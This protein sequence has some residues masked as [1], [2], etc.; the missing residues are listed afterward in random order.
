MSKLN[1]AKADKPDQKQAK[2][3]I[4]IWFIQYTV[5]DCSSIYLSGL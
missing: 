5:F 2:L 3:N 4:K 1:W